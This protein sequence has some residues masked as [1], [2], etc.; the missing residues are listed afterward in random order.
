M[1]L[2]QQLDEFKEQ[3]LRTAPAG[4]TQAACRETSIRSSALLKR[5]T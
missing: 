4:R 1:G 3:S 2:E 5:P